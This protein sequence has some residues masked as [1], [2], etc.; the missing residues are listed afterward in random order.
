MLLNFVFQKSMKRVPKPDVADSKPAEVSDVKINPV[1][2][3]RPVAKD[4]RTLVKDRFGP[5]LDSAGVGNVDRRRLGS[6]G[7]SKSVDSNHFP[8]AVD[9]DEHNSSD[10]KEEVTSG[11][12]SNPSCLR[13]N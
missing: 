9:V 12:T 5:S 8:H 11:D 10:D 3:L 6:L 13:R 7:Q 4:R 1:Y 2:N